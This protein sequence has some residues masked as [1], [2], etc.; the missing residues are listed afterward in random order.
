M[1]RQA[2]RQIK[3]IVAGNIRAARDARGLTQREIAAMANV[4]DGLAVSR[5]ENERVAP[6][7]ESLVALADALG[8]ELAWFYTD[9]DAQDVAA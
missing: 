1:S 2:T 4:S 5:W 3:S 6:S 8:L 7:T 9:H